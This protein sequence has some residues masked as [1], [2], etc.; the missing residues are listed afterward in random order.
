MNEFERCIEKGRLLRVDIAPA[1]LE[2]ELDEASKDHAQAERRLAS[3]RFEDASVHAYHAMYHAARTLLLA[4]GYRERNLYCLAAGLRHH[5]VSQGRLDESL[6]KTLAQLKDVRDR[7]V[8][9]ARSD[10]GE[11]HSAVAASAAMIERARSLMAEESGA[12]E[13]QGN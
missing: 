9:G 10:R 6:L 4:R 7:I 3:G 12:P 5:Y 1:Q 8:N 13:G 2:H 11:A